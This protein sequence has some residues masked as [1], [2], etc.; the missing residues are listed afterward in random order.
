MKVSLYSIDENGKNNEWIG[1]CLTTLKDILLSSSGSPVSQLF[2][3]KKNKT[4]SC[5]GILSIQNATL[6]EK[7]QWKNK[8]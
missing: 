3:S 6:S 5:T 7:K 4:G 8:Q 1:S 2:L